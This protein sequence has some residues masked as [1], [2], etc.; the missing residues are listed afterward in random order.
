MN[1]EC[2]ICLENISLEQN[3]Y[4]CPRCQILVHINC[5]QGWEKVKR[6]NNCPSCSYAENNSQDDIVNVDQINEDVIFLYN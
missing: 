5:K 3:I 4:T 6:S 1:T 2:I